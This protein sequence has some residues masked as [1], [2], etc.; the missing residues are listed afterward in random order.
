MRIVVF[1]SNKCHYCQMQKESLSKTFEKDDWLYIDLLKDKDAIQLAKDI[2]IE[3][4][5]SLVIL[6]SSFQELYR[7]DGIL[8][9]DQIYKILVGGSNFYP[10]P[11]NLKE[12]VQNGSLK[13]IFLSYDPA[14]E[15]GD[16]ISL[17]TYKGDI[18][19][20]ATVQKVHK[21]DLDDFENKFGAK[22]KEEYLNVVGIS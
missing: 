3:N 14:I 4:I 1:G 2:D 10:V 8:P 22:L 12:Q 19:K 5:P 21:L 11:N 13:L 17:V 9:P 15:K 6:N 7:K 16:T 20:K 18:L